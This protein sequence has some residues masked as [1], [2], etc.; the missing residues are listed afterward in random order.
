V[1]L[2]TSGGPGYSTEVLSVLAYDLAFTSLAVGR[3]AA[4]AVVMGLFGLLAAVV[5]TRFG[6]AGR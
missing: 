1:Y 5:Y 2:S 3:A 6:W 4:V